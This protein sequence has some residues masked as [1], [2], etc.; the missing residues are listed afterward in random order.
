MLYALKKIVAAHPKA[1]LYGFGCVIAAAYMF[2]VAPRP[3]KEFFWF[4]GLGFIVFSFIK[5]VQHHW[6][7]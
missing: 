6:D 3:A 4:V 2:H 7:D 5:F 1:F